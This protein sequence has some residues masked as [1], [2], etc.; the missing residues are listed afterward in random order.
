PRLGM[1]VQEREVALAQRNQMAARAEVGLD[2]A[3]ARAV[4]EDRETGVVAGLG[5]A[6]LVA[7]VRYR[8]RG[9]VGQGARL[10]RAVGVEV[11][12]EVVWLSVAAEVGKEA[13]AAGVGKPQRDLPAA[14]RVLSRVQVLEA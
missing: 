11:D 14:V 13:V 4:L 2:V 5:E 7:A 3:H 10:D 1:D 8:R 6:H 12:S 9:G